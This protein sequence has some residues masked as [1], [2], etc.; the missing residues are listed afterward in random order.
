MLV[1]ATWLAVTPGA[2]LSSRTSFDGIIE[3]LNAFV[4]Y[5]GDPGRSGPAMLALFGF[6]PLLISGIVRSWSMVWLAPAA[7]V[8]ADAVLQAAARLAGLTRSSPLAP[9]QLLLD[10]LVFCLPAAIAATFGTLAGRGL[11]GQGRW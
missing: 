6:A 10:A 1:A 11:A 4:G 7:V 8:L 9:S 2:P 5:P 3:F